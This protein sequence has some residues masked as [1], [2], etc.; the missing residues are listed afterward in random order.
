MIEKSNLLSNT[1]QVT[2]C[3]LK[4]PISKLNN[5]QRNLMTRDMV[6]S[7]SLKR[8]DLHHTA[9]SWTDCGIRFTPCSTNAYFIHTTKAISPLRNKY[10]HLPLR[11][12]LVLKKPKWNMSSTLSISEIQS[13]T[14]FTGKDS[15][16]K[17]MN[18][19]LLRNSPM[20]KW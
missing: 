2:W 6:C 7:R 15:H 20:H 1:N 4:Q 10:C 8:K 13:I 3:F 14:S 17:K 5:H 9:S 18:G 16:A 19:F 11:L 12:S